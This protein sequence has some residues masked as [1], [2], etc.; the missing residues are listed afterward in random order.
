MKMPRP[1]TADTGRP[2]NQCARCNHRFQPHWIEDLGRFSRCCSD[3]E[4]RNLADALRLP[5]LYVAG[6][7]EPD[8]NTPEMP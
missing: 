3:C 1:N 6:G 8:E 2:F 7:I 4:L 5:E